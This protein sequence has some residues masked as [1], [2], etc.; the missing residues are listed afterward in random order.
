MWATTMA[1]MVMKMHD[2]FEKSPTLHHLKTTT[3]FNPFTNIAAVLTYCTPDTLWK[4]LCN[5]YGQHKILDTYVHKQED[6]FHVYKVFEL[7]IKEAIETLFEINKN[8]YDKLLKTTEDYDMFSPYHISEEHVTGTRQANT[9]NTNG[10]TI[11]ETGSET[12]FDSAS[13]HT[14]NETVTRPSGSN[15]IDY[16]S[17]KSETFGEGT[18]QKTLENLTSSSKS[19]DSRVG[20]IGNHT[21]ADIIEKERETAN[22]SLYDVICRDVINEICYKIF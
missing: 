17:S 22:F 9:T 8:K 18:D 21:Y 19:Y 14:T 1:R 11:T 6:A 12:S 13:L 3:S 2:V 10:T 15:T 4:Y 20:N 5:H 7:E 16:G